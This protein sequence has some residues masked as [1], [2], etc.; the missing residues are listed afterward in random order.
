[1]H[2]PIGWSRQSS[3]TSSPSL[4][5]FMATIGGLYFS[6]VIVS[7]ANNLV[8]EIDASASVTTLIDK[9]ESDRLRVAHE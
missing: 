8:S 2:N 9:A 4:G 1:M 6:D 5:E 7:D 3:A